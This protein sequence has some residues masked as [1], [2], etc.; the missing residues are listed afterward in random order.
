MA[1]ALSEPGEIPDLME[2]ELPPDGEVETWVIITNVGTSNFPENAIILASGL[3]GVVD[4][5]YYFQ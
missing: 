3:E 1:V 5:I 4:V 2:V